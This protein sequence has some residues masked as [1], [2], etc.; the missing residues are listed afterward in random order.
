MK[1]QKWAALAICLVLVFGALPQAAFAGDGPCYDNYGTVRDS[2]TW[3][4]KTTKSPTCTGKGTEVGTCKYCGKT[5][6]RSIPAKGHNFRY[7]K[8]TQEPTCTEDGVAL[9]TCPQCSAKENR[10]IK[11]SGHEWSTGVI[12]KE[13]GYLAP[14]ITTYTCEK[15][16]ETRTEEI[17]PEAGLVMSGDSA[18]DFLNNFRDV[19]ITVKTGADMLHITKQPEGG[20]IPWGEYFVRETAGRKIRYRDPNAEDLLLT[21]EVAGGEEPYTYRWYKATMFRMK[22]GEPRGHTIGPDSPE[23]SVS[24]AAHYYC[25]ITDAAGAWVRSDIVEAKE[26]LHFALQPQ[27]TSIYG[28]DSVT[29]SCRAE[30]GMLFDGVE[31]IYEWFTATG[32]EIPGD[33]DDSSKLTVSE[34]GEYYCVATDGAGATVSSNV[35]LVYS[36][37]D[38]SLIVY[39]HNKV[40]LLGEDGFQAYVKADGGLLPYT[41]VW[42]KEG[43]VLV[44]LTTEENEVYLPVMDYGAYVCTL[45]DDAGATVSWEFNMIYPQLRIQVQPT[46]G[47]LPDGGGKHP[48]EI[49]MQEGTVPFSFAL[50]RNG[51]LYREKNDVPE[52]RVILS[53]DEPGIYY[54]RVEDVDGRW[55]ES[56]HVTISDY[57]LSIKDYSQEATIRDINRPVLLDVRVEGGLPPYQYMWEASVN[58]GAYK[59][60]KTVELNDTLCTIPVSM[61]G[62][63]RCTVTDGYNHTAFASG[64][65]VSYSDPVPLIVEQP[66]DV[67]LPYADGQV[68]YQVTLKCKAV[69]GD[70]QDQFLDY[71]W[72]T[73]DPD[74]GFLPYRDGSILDIT[75]LTRSLSFRC[76]VTDTRTNHKAV[77]DMAMV[78]IQL[79]C[80]TPET[81]EALSSS[82]GRLLYGI[83]GGMAPY[84][85]QVMQHRILTADNGKVERIDALEKEFFVDEPSEELELDFPCIDY[86]FIWYDDFGRPTVQK[87]RIEYFLIVTDRLYQTV[88]TP[89]MIGSSGN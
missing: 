50:Y 73:Y 77:S 27:N 60:E 24:T 48:L 66:E 9:Y 16:G 72:E 49:A 40:D 87:T 56:A 51:D 42:K 31:Y 43:T 57:Q 78:S 61:P 10:T 21:V 19:Q 52:S 1:F 54:Y 5:K 68:Y 85:V 53:V 29:L 3:S 79:L 28:L 18:N 58:G 33:S 89:V 36:W 14:G 7:L 63:Y 76:T 11:A 67:V 86:E 39:G 23:L 80:I 88:T 55:A 4:W 83:K 35:A 22:D 13:P 84:E 32:M 2:H 44:E 20:M 25:E 41:F 46:G 69:V 62:T 26:S 81:Y 8:T 34:P 65:Q 59:P 6:T 12:T 74:D 70:G 15:C 64:I 45:T 38:L 71:S 37:K 30:G 82:K 75:D 17:P 47:V